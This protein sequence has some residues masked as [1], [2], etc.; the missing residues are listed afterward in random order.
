MPKIEV[1][2]K[3]FWTLTGEKLGYAALEEKLTCAKA[4]LDGTETDAASG[5][6]IIKIELNDTNRPD[7]W[8]TSG[9]ARALRVHRTAKTVDYMASIT[10]K[11]SG[12]ASD[13]G[14]RIVHVD[15]ALKDIRPFM[16]AFVISGKKIDEPM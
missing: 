6:K 16:C 7:L 8:S 11:N 12:F 4:E 3:L 13:Y 15:A 5:E 1:N 14:E 10:E 2:E 9:V